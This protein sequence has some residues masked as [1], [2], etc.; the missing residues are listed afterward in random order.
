MNYNIFTSKVL[1]FWNMIRHFTLFIS[2]LLLLL[3]LL[4]VCL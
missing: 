4:A 3:L 2:V 1:K